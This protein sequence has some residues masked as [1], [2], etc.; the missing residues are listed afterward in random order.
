M[1]TVENVKKFY[2]GTNGNFDKM[3][4]RILKVLEN[5][6]QIEVNVVLAYLNFKTENVYFDIAD[7]IFPD[8]LEKTPF[9]FAINRRNEYMIKNSHYIICCVDNTLTNSYKYIEIALR[10]KLKII[11][12][13]SLDIK[14]TLSG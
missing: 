12:I 4:Y 2:V 14:K 9:R 10:N 7:T 3:V 8:I 1:I 5:E 6:Y 11:N 13:G